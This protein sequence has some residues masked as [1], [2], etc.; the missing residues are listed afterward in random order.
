VRW[1]EPGLIDAAVALRRGE[2]ALL[3][4]SAVEALLAAVANRLRDASAE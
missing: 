1:A 4:E 2:D 3:E